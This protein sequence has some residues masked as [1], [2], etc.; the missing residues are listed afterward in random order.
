MDF[1]E[2]YKPPQMYSKGPI[3]SQA[4]SIVKGS[5]RTQLQEP[6]KPPSDIDYLAVSAGAAVCMRF[7]V[8]GN[9]RPRLPSAL[10]GSLGCMCPCSQHLQCCAQHALT[11]MVWHRLAHCLRSKT[12]APG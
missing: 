6:D 3:P 7:A 4:E 9:V 10:T 1:N 8:T 2:A 11:T 5:P 12:I